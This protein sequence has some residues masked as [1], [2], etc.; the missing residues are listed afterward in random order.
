MLIVDDDPDLLSLM[1]ETLDLEG[2]RVDTSTNGVRALDAVEKVM[3]DLILLDMKMPVMDGAEF[4]KRFREAHDHEAPIVIVTAADNAH[5]SANE[6]GANGWLGKPF[7]LDSL[8]E[9]VA[10][11]VGAADSG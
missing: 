5:R 4:A 8:L 11:Q 2:Y 9:I 3:P 1:A 6:I 7:D 10:S